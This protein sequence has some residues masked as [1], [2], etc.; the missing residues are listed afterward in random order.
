[1]KKIEKYRKAG[2]ELYDAL[3][4]STF[5][6]A[7]KYI[8]R[9]REIPQGVLRPSS[10]GKK[11][12]LCQAFTQSRRWGA[13]VAM[14]SDDNFC[15]P[16]TAMHRWV[17]ISKEDLI[18]SQV[19]QGWHK[20]AAAEK[21]RISSFFEFLSREG[22][23]KLEHYHGLICSPLPDTLVVPDVVLVYG[24]GV[25][26]T[27]IIHALSYEYKHVPMS[28]F[29]GFAE[30]CMKGGLLPFVTGRP[31][32]VIPGAGDRSFAGITENELGIGIPASLLAYVLD[33]LFKTGGMMNIGYPLRQILPTDLSEHLT[34]G[35]QFM[36]EKIDKKAGR[37]LG[38]RKA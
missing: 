8:K 35:F 37:G 23:E 26:L 31:Q 34:P 21:M 36:R 30:S 25:Q 29:E 24:D 20:N 3:H 28:F 22:L 7:I 17:D 12:A 11:M 38:R 2:R 32:I 10:F 5:P 13:T 9:E 1:M 14:T 19:I 27:H 15:T 16:A 18:K 4:L 33:N 6:V